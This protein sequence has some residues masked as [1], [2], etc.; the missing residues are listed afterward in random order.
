MHFDHHDLQPPPPAIISTW[1]VTESEIRP[2]V[3]DHLKNL[4]EAIRTE[5]R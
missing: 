4:A 3:F 2:E 5:F 1:E